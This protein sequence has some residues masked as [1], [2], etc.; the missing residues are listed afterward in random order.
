M[1]FET[2]PKKKLTRAQAM[3]RAQAS[4]AYQERCQQEMRDKLY[5]WGLHS[6]DVEN[7]I[8]ELITDNFLNEERFA[9]TFAGGKFRI[10]KWGKIKIKIELKR[11]KIS[12]YCIRRAMLEISDMDYI[13]TLQQLII[14]KSKDIKGGKTQV[15]NYKIAQYAISRGFEGDLVWDILRE[16]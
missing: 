6:A 12:D 8:A 13:K 2:K 4:C 5:E 10:K 15:K 16:E 11:R 9:K 1:D 14:K 3:I 7:I